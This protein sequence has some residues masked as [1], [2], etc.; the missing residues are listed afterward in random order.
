MFACLLMII[1]ITGTVNNCIPLDDKL[2][3]SW[4]VNYSQSNIR[5][6]LCGCHSTMTK[7]VF[8]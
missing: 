3:L 2:Q 5:F 1:F 8:R 4:K 6:E 7:Y